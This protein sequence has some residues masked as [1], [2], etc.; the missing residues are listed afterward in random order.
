M[1]VHYR[2]VFISDVHLGFN[3]SRAGD[4]LEF[5]KLV[6][7]DYLYLVG[8]I[9]DL[10][11]MKSKVSWNEDCTAVIRRILKMN[12]RGTSVIFIPGN[13]DEAIR[14]FTPFELGESIMFTDE[15]IHET[16]AGLRLMVIHGD[17]F[18]PVV[19][20]MKWIA[21][22]GN[23]LY[24]WLLR[25][26]GVFHRLR[27]MVGFKSYWSLAAFLKHRAKQAVSFINDFETAALQYSSSKNCDGVICGHIHT[28][29]VS[30]KGAMLYANCGDWVE[31]CSALVEQEDG[32][33][34]LLSW[35][36]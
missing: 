35:F 34:R 20:N 16:A 29:K 33:I 11:A 23:V 4:L 14:Q 1:K 28:P 5:L 22:L 19:G 9:F 32:E 27:T 26:N 7:C 21:K 15:A 18:D 25:L 6:E 3:G 10:W 31:S 8:D 12:K 24:D 30:F 17:R 2:S 13:H 36:K